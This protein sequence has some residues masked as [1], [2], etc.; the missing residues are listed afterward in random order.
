MFTESKRVA[1]LG[2]SGYA[3]GEL[4]R[5]V[6]GH[7]NLELVH[8]GAHSR[9][10]QPLSSVHPH[11][12]GGERVLATLEPS[13]VPEIDVVFFALPHGASAAPAMQLL[14]RGAVLVD[15][16]SD[17]RM[18]D[19][20]RYTEAYG[21]EHPAPE[22]LGSWVYGLP[23]LFGK[24]LIGA[25]RIAV[26]GCYPTGALLG[27]APLVTAGLVDTSG[28]IVD[29]LSGVS[30]AGRSVKDN[31]HYGAA[32]EN[33]TAYG[34]VTHRHRPEI[35]QGL[36]AVGAV[37]PVVTFTPHLVPMLRGE[38]TTSYCKT[39]ASE[40]ELAETL[41]RAYADAPFVRVVDEPPQTRWV[42]GSNNAMV[43]VRVDQHAGLAIIV[44]AIDNLLKGAAGQAVQCV[45]VS[46][47]WEETLGLPST[48]AMP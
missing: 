13:E 24:H 37:D 12:S 29:S 20:V 32:S 4:V 42:V 2:A 7:P 19:P 31:L 9:A 27:L 44:S 23:E 26:P 5:L 1:I 25:D 22:Q 43:T 47:G 10:G 28:V 34:L 46:Y 21:I 30:G 40:E 18:T 33:A 48:G 36:E 11:L 3:G 8:I 17:F 6:D 16:G 15:L 45:N 38:L 14:N 35:E 39:E 41:T